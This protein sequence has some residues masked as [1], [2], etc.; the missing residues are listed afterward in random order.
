M[1]GWG[2][3]GFDQI[4]FALDKDDTGP[5]EFLVTGEKLVPPVYD[6]PESR[7]RGNNLCSQPQLA[8]RYENGITVTLGNGNRGGGIFV[9][10]KGRVEIFRERFTSSPKELAENYLNEHADFKMPSH[11]ANW[12]NC[13]YNG[14]TPIGDIETGIRTATICHILNIARYLGRSLKWDPVKE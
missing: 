8:Y 13:I 4:Q 5:I 2:T 9:G 14:N 12:I 7:D 1:T 10:E 6:K 3:H 11:T